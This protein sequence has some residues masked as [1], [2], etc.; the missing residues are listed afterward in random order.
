MRKI[1]GAVALALALMS[2]AAA[3]AKDIPAGGFTVA[4]VAAWLQDQGYRAQIVT[5]KD[6]TKHVSSATSG[7]DFGVYLYDCKGERCGSI[8]FAAGW[9][10]HGSFDTAR[11]NE[12][13]RRNRW[14]RGY[15][16][17]A[18]DPWLEY[19]IDLTPGGTYELL[20]DELATWNTSVTNFVKLYSLH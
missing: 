6:G 1:A 12:W 11:M 19:D 3:A 10:T 9:A 20:N 5:D 18:K 13:N 16:D 2:A 15:Y 8:Q 4:D 7:V 17:D 14:A